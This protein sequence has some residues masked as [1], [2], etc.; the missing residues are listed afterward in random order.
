MGRKH[1][2]KWVSLPLGGGRAHLLGG[3]AAKRAPAPPQRWPP[4]VAA[5]GTGPARHSP[6]PPSNFI[7][8]FA[9]GFSTRMYTQKAAIKDTTVKETKL[10]KNTLG[11]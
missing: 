2:G 7:W 10:K 11:E 5:R 3:L 1:C 4:R 8:R 6:P 9:A